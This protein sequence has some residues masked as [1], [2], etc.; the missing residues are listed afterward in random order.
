MHRVQ[1]FTPKALLVGKVIS[2]DVEV[3]MGHSS[4]EA[5]LCGQSH[6]PRVAQ[7]ACTRS[8]TSLCQIRVDGTPTLTTTTTQHISLL[9]LQR[10]CIGSA[11]C[12][13][14]DV[15][16]RCRGTWQATCLL[17]QVDL[18]TVWA[19]VKN[20]RLDSR[21]LAS[22]MFFCNA[23]QAQIHNSVRCKQPLKAQLTKH[24]RRSHMLKH[25]CR[26]SLCQMLGC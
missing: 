17:Q 15:L 18:P 23:H 16:C 21:Y 12:Q 26:H 20:M 11:F 4:H 2:L 7:Q 13:Q 25:G 22:H 8:Q 24:S 14:T 10:L 6:H 3:K 5:T 1:H 19:T 9:T